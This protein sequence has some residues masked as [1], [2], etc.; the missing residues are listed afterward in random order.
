MHNLSRKA[1]T[2]LLLSAAL[3]ATGT[4]AVMSTTPAQAVDTCRIKVHTLTSHE[5]QDNDSS[6]EIQFRLGDNTSGV[7]SFPD[8]WERHDSL[9]HPIE[10]YV[11]SVSFSLWDKD[12]V[13]KT[14]ID[15]D[16]VT[17]CDEGWH[18]MDLV[19]KGAIYTMQYELID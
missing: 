1:R 6:D 19:G 2:S 3:A 18:D 13:V 4:F 5:L 7:F 11:T 12:S 10:D 17:G 8:D 15:T 9:N 16:T 14:T